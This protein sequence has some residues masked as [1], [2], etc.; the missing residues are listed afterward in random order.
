M[1][2]HISSVSAF[3]GCGVLEST[4]ARGPNTNKN[5]S[6]H[7]SYHVAS[8][9]LLTANGQGLQNRDLRMLVNPGVSTKL[10]KLKKWRQEM[11]PFWIRWP[12]NTYYSATVAGATARIY[13]LTQARCKLTRETASHCQYE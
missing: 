9:A 13:S 3:D 7:T 12:K 2:H 10:Q 4:T 5:S 8:F 11:N 6:V 1:G